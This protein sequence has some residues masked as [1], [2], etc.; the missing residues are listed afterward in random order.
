MNE[1]CEHCNDCEHQDWHGTYPLI[2]QN[3][4]EYNP[5]GCCTYRDLDDEEE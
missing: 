4:P 3:D 2:R 5:C 1:Y